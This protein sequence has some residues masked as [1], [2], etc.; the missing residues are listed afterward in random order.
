MRLLVHPGYP[1]TATTWLQT[2]VLPQ[3]GVWQ[4]GKGSAADGS[5]DRWDPLVR[6]VHYRVFSSVYGDGRIWER[7]RNSTA[8][9]VEYADVLAG[10]L[11]AA[12]AGRMP[13]SAVVNGGAT[14]LAV[15]S[16][17]TMLAY[18]GVELNA[19]LLSYLLNAVRE[20]LDDPARVS[21]ELVLT[22]R[23]QRSFLRSFFAYVYTLQRDRYADFG[24][25]V[26][27]G[28]A[29]PRADAFGMLFY[30]EAVDFLGHALP[31]FVRIR[32][33]PYEVL[34]VD[35]ARPFVEAFLGEDA[36][37]ALAR[38]D[39]AAG[40][41][42]V[43][44]SEHGYP[45]RDLSARRFPLRRLRQRRAALSDD[46]DRRVSELYA[47]SNRRL[48]ASQRLDLGRLGYAV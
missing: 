38:V 42:L 41:E 31:D 16:D 19:G 10:E 25:F 33:V 17:E 47:P 4:L 1:K 6:D 20:R 37:A 27:A 40:G 15:L 44:R 13:A 34:A 9:L 21:W 5:E 35:G 45:L 23:E 28:L 32:V 11:N 43:N 8:E 7:F 22:V 29:R 2:L 26:E 36:S 39:L 18:G 30:D 24:E 3:A 12:A 48:A 14:D 46:Q